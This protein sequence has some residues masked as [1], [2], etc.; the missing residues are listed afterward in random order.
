MRR[1]RPRNWVVPVLLGCAAAVTGANAAPQLW[2]AVAEPGVRAGLD[3]VYD[4]LRTSV[5]AMFALFTIGRAA[6]R[7]RSRS[8]VAFAGCAVALGA[9]AAFRNPPPGAPDVL[10]L[11]GDAVAV[12]SCGWVLMSVLCLGR[13]F[14]I[15]P[16]ARGLV[17]RGPYRIVRHPVYLG[18][19]GACTGLAIAAPGVVNVVALVAVIA[20]QFVRMSLEETALRAAFP[21]YQSYA[22]EVPQVVP[23]VKRGLTPRTMSQ[24]RARAL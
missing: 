19:M 15:L 11:A 9:T 22:Q 13:C 3:A 5:T 21:A 14:G 12:A 10:V 18:E 2:H 6:P 17:R 20:A 24:S 8:L 23:F 7:R 1:L 16:E 4:L